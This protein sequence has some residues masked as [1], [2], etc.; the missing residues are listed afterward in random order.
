MTKLNEIKTGDILIADGGFTCLREGQSC[1]A[2]HDECDSLYID[3]DEGQH[4]LDAQV[5]ENDDLVGLAK[6]II[7][8]D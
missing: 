6:K 2:K 1:E 5:D 3:C 7:A 4:R 8:A